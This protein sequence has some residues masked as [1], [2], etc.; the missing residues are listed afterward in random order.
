M[1]NVRVLGKTPPEPR[2][3]SEMFVGEQG[4]TV[5]WAYRGGVLN[6]NSTIDKKGGTSTLW[7]RCDGDDTYTIK[8]ESI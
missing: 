5:P 1:T 2:K 8:F 4:Y 7:I 6:T 3:I